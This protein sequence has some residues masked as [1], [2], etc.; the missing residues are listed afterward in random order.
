[1]KRLVLLAASLVFSLFL[2][3]QQ[4]LPSD[5]I[6]ID[7]SHPSLPDNQPLVVVNGN[8]TTMD[9]LILDP[10][11]ISQIDILKDSSAT[12]IYGG[13]GINGV[14]IIT[15]KPGTNFKRL[16]DFMNEQKGL[17]PSIKNVELNGKLL[18]D[19]SKLLIDTKAKVTTLIS[20]H[21]SFDKNCA[22]TVDDTLVI[23]T[24]FGD[25]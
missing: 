8:S 17:N 1:M 20:S 13:Y 10:N 14:I 18:P 12:A 22:T 23:S 11:N 25:N 19:M 3:A 6:R 7:G 21:T 9:A 4:Q 2:F 15:T 16:D 5:R 24:K